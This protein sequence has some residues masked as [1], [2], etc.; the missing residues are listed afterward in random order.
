MADSTAE[1]IYVLYK[2]FWNDDGERDI[3]KNWKL[4]FVNH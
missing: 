2:L 3:T 1:S 4:P